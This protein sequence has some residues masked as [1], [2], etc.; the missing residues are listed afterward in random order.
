[1]AFGRLKIERPLPKVRH[2]RNGHHASQYHRLQSCHELSFR[3]ADT[4]FLSATSS[5]VV[6]NCKTAAPV[7]G[8]MR[9]FGFIARYLPSVEIDSPLLSFSPRI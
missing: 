9:V 1:V 2:D 8:Q 5:N 7:I 3:I 6:L 4:R